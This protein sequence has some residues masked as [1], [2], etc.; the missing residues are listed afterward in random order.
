MHDF[1]RPDGIIHLFDAVTA[2]AGEVD[3]KCRKLCVNFGVDLRRYVVWTG[4]SVHTVLQ[5]GHGPKDHNQPWHF[6][7]HI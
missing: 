6:L 1:F 2:V 3:D 7:V 5:A 4:L